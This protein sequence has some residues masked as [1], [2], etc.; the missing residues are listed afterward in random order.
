MDE[1]RSGAAAEGSSEEAKAPYA[2]DGLWRELAAGL[3]AY[4]RGMTDPD[5]ADHLLIEIPDANPEGVGCPPYAQFAAFGDGSMVRAEI[6]GNAYLLPQ[7][8]LDD[9]GFDYLLAGGWEGP[10]DDEDSGQNWFIH[11]PVSEVAAV[12]DRVVNTLRFHFGIAHPQLLTYKAWGPAAAEASVLGLCATAD[13]PV[14][15]PQAPKAQRKAGPRPKKGMRAVVSANRDELVEL[16]SEAL[17]RKYDEE[18]D[19]D[20]DGD[21]VLEHMGQ[22][23]WVRVRHDSPDRRDHGPRRPRRLLPAGDRRRDR[24][25][26]PRPPV[27]ALDPA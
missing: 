10:A 13:V 22:L 8:R 14:D 6:S 3:A 20:D 26:Q 4:L 2:I 15:E 17:A 27:G 21:F 11:V 5:E 1:G 9:A 12:A 23:A 16:V 24:A 25:A 19:V 18:P 7:Y